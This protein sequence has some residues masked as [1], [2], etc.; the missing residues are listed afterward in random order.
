MYRK[1][2]LLLLVIIVNLLILLRAPYIFAVNTYR[3]GPYEE[4]GDSFIITSDPA[5]QSKTYTFGKGQTIYVRLTTNRFSDKIL[6]DVIGLNDYRDIQVAQSHLIQKTYSVPFIFEGSITVPSEQNTYITLNIDFSWGQE[7]L[8][9]GEALLSQALEVITV[10]QNL[11][12]YGDASYNSEQ[13]VFK[14]SDTLYAR[15]YGAGENVESATF[16]FG[17]INSAQQTHPVPKQNIQHEG[18]WYSTAFDLSQLQLQD[19]V[20]YMAGFVLHDSEN[21][22][23]AAPTKFFRTDDTAPSVTI[24]TPASQD[25]VGGAINIIGTATDVNFKNFILSVRD[26][27]DT[28]N[29]WIQLID[30]TSLIQNNT[31]YQWDTSDYGGKTVDIKLDSFDHARNFSSVVASNIKIDGA[32]SLKIP[33]S[34]S[35]LPVTSSTQRVIAYASIGDGNG[36]DVV[37]QDLRVKKPGWTVTVS[38]SDFVAI[39]GVIPVTNLSIIP[40]A[41][42][43]QN[44]T[45]DG[46]TVGNNH[47]FTSTHDVAL[48]MSASVGNGFGRYMQQEGL[49][50]IVPENTPAGSYS[51]TA[52]FTVQ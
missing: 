35:F 18:N 16:I 7:G 2:G 43:T 6:T 26:I 30:S 15:L 31:L 11:R 4:Q 20:W 45:L 32:F 22:I 5:F 28:N 34:A 3:E 39:D 21:K 50:L 1:Y 48:L 17:K 29:T 47:L 9:A 25:T 10:D 33:A 42:T 40:R 8:V 36:N 37:I 41:V 38:F 23:I 46:I 52:T 44:G 24:T 19:N 27:G 51:G 14:S 12:L 13:Y 49:E